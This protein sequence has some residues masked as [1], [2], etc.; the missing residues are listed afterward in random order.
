MNPTALWLSVFFTV[1]L[2]LNGG[3]GTALSAPPAQ[4]SAHQ[5]EKE[6]YGSLDGVP[7]LL[8]TDTS[9]HGKP[10]FGDLDSDG[11]PDLL[12]GRFDGTISRYEASVNNGE[13]SWRLLTEVMS[14]FVASAEKGRQPVEAPV[15]VSSDSAPALVDIDSDG[16]LDLFVG[17]SREGISFYRNVG[18]PTLAIFHLEM[19]QFMDTSFG[20][21]LTPFFADVDGNRTP[22][23]VVG[24]NA[25]EVFLLINNG[26]R[27]RPGFCVRFPPNDALPGEE[28]PCKPT[29]RLIAAIAP[30]TNAVPTLVD[31]DGDDDTDLFIGVNNGGMHYYRNDGS[32]EQPVWRLNQKRFLGID[33]GGSL[34]PRFLDVNGDGIPDLM[35]GD[36]TN[37][38]TLYTNKGTGSRDDV[39]KVT[40]NVLGTARF[41]QGLRRIVISSGDVDGDKDLDLVLGERGG[42]ILLVRNIGKSNQPVWDKKPE[43]LGGNSA[44]GNSAPWLVD[45][46]SD[47][48]LDLLV[49]G[50]DGRLWLMRNR[51][52][53]AKIQLV[54]EETSLGGIDVGSDSVPMTKDIDGDGDQDLF[55]GNGKGH[56]IFF[57][58]EGTKD[59]PAFK[60]VSTRFGNVISPG[61][62][63]PAFFDWDA[64]GLSDMVVGNRQG[65]IG[66]ALNR[67]GEQQEYPRDW[68]LQTKNQ[69]GF[70]GR[71]YAAPHFVDLN[72]DGLVDLLLGDFEGNVQL[73]WNRGRKVSKV[74]KPATMAS[75]GENQSEEV[76]TAIS[77]PTPVLESAPVFAREEAVE[78]GPAQVELAAVTE[79]A[80]PLP[81]EY[82]LESTKYGGIEYKHRVVPTFGDLDNDGD[83]D[84]LVGVGNGTVAYYRNDGSP[85]EAKW[86]KV[87][88][89]LIEK[90]PGKLPSVILHDLDE[91]LRL[92]LL[93]GLD[94]GFVKLYRNTVKSGDPKFELEPEALKKVRVGHN[95]APSVV[96]LNEDNTTDLVVGDFSGKLVSFLR[97]GGKSSF[98]FKLNNRNF[99]QLD[100]GVGATPFVGDVD[101]DNV[102]DLLIGSD[103]GQV[104]RLA[105]T[106][107]TKKSPQ[108]WARM[109]SDLKKLPVPIGSTPRLADIDGDKDLDLFLGTEKGTIYFY[110][111]SAIRPDDTGEAVPIQ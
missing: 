110:K 71:R 80:G 78:A 22:D 105:R 4:E 108:G 91:D 38:M 13:I 101:R 96:S 75:E 35:I 55:V 27:Q 19:K 12:V 57:R 66:L 90:L 8:H 67:S 72:G 50:K 41:G 62:A 109:P 25:G 65:F 95:A 63:A 10:A 59:S 84:L 1:L 86:K 79:P 37:L 31:W 21:N 44:R 98:N 85:T 103:Q 81:P 102:P 36:S 106:G 88:D 73:W 76:E 56:V 51:G 49:G 40:K 69:E 48:D 97:E 3:E 7:R 100:V 45:I 60:L 99:L 52:T 24:N 77:P 94:S 54:L 20:K 64:D 18:T 111:N 29:P 6:F 28:P 9:I 58:N 47:G 93:V 53:A 30:E 68:E 11:D 74:A 70:F 17:S 82:S 107:V 39:W 89:T 23:M 15:S 92:E 34:A 16:D 104:F 43:R 33:T 42:D 46:D 32:P 26:D 87:T 2:I 14:G 5:W 61:N 83:L